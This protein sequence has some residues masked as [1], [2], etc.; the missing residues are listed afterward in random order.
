MEPATDGAVG[1]GRDAAIVRLGEGRRRGRW[2]RW[3]RQVVVV[4]VLG[5]GEGKRLALGSKRARWDSAR[6]GRMNQIPRIL[7]HG[8]A[9]RLRIWV[10]TP[11]GE[12]VRKP[13]EMSNLM[14]EGVL[15]ETAPDHDDAFSVEREGGPAAAR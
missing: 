1:R 14:R 2:R 12:G 11:S 10:A 6:G 4:E 3:G 13:E 7:E 5:P 9:A 15:V 8:G